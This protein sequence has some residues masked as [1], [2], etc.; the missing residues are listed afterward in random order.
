MSNVFWLVVL[1]FISLNIENLH[2]YIYAL[3]LYNIYLKDSYSYFS[4]DILEQSILMFATAVRVNAV[5]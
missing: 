4:R 3:C 2:K 5:C 1:N